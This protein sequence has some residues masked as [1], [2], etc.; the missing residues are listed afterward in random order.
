MYW[1]IF[2]VVGVNIILIVSIHFTLYYYRLLRNSFILVYRLSS[3]TWI[4]FCY[5]SQLLR[6]T[7]TLLKD[8]IVDWKSCFEWG[9][10]PR[11][12]AHLSIFRPNCSANCFVGAFYIVFEAYNFF[13]IVVTLCLHFI[14]CKKDLLQIV[15]IWSR[16][17]RILFIVHFLLLST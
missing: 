15:N 10:N 3:E 12:C 5:H 6:I 1:F 9:S 14:F 17:V 4:N 8:V 11:P 13:F 2:Y 7:H 16:V